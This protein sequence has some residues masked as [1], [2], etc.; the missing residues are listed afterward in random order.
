MSDKSP[1]GVF[2]EKALPQILD[3][4]RRTARL[5]L[6]GVEG[7]KD[8]NGRLSGTKRQIDATIHLQN[9]QNIFVESRQRSKKRLD[10][11]SVEAFDA[12]CRLDIGQ[13]EKDPL[14]IVTTRG[15]S[16]AAI[17][18]A[19]KRNIALVKFTC[20]DETLDNYNLEIMDHPLIFELSR[21]AATYREIVTQSEHE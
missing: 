2:Y 16:K 19:Q 5:Q 11:A 20:K 6:S 7:S 18:Y 1:P 10:I 15:F 4:L 17:S 3:Y 13:D 21:R 9:G 14:I 8:Y 12:K